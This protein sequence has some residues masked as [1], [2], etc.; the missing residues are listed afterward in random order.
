LRQNAVIEDTDYRTPRGLDR[1]LF[2]KLAGCEWIRSSQHLAIVGPTGVGK[3]LVSL[4]P[5]SQG[6]SSGADLSRTRISSLKR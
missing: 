4:R 1:A 3:I 6:V 5:R 2:H